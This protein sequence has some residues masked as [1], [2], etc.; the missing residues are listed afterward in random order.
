MP[1]FLHHTFVV[2]VKIE[3]NESYHFMKRSHTPTFK[4][5]SVIVPMLVIDFVTGHEELHFLNRDIFR[6]VVMFEYKGKHLEVI[7]S[8][9]GSS[10]MYFVHLHSDGLVETIGVSDADKATKILK[11]KLR[12]EMLMKTLTPRGRKLRARAHV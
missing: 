2:H 7:V 8:D 9:N 5:D 6:N 1:K 12:K 11:H 3:T 4:M 10:H